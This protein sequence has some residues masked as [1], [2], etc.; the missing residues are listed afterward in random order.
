MSNLDRD[1]REAARLGYGVHYGRYKA[2]HPHTAPAVEDGPPE[3]TV[4]CGHCGS[5]FVPKRYNQR[6]CC[7]VC[8]FRHN[9]WEAYRRNK[10][11]V[12]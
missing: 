7:D 9:N 3:K 6:Y 10:A 8:K 12:K 5:L 2:D 11:N 4:A 1:V